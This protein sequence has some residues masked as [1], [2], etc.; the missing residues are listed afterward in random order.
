MSSKGTD[1]MEPVVRLAALVAFA[2]SAA[3]A[4]AQ[5]IGEREYMN[6]CASCHGPDGKGDGPLAGFLTTALPD[7][8]QLAKDNGGV[9]PVASMY[10]MIEG[11]GA[12]GPHGSREMPAW[13]DRYRIAGEAVANPDFDTDEAEVYARFRILALIEHLSTLQEE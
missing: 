10:S 5:S 2:L 11:V 7:L 9:F 4:G 8:T 13:G 3:A 12:P 6:S 1:P